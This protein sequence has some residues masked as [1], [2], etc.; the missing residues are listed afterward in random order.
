MLLRNF[1]RVTNICKKFATSEPEILVHENYPTEITIIFLDNVPTEEQ[2]E[3]IFE[4]LSAS[5][6]NVLNNSRLELDFVSWIV[7]TN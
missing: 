4:A 2:R 5:F 3:Q 1:K 6:K 7:T